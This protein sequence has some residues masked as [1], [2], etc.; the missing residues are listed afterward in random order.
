MS[1]TPPRPPHPAGRPD[2]RPSAVVS[3]SSFGFLL[4]ATLVSLAPALA[5]AADTPDFSEFRLIAERNIFNPE[6]SPRREDR[7]S[8]EERRP[9]RVESFALVGTMSYEKGRFAF[10]DGSDASYRTIVPE[11]GSLAGFVVREITTAGVQLERDGTRL[12]LT[13]NAGMRREEEGAWQPTERTEVLANRGGG[14]RSD[15]D[16][17]RRS[18]SE[19]G[20]DRSARRSSDTASSPGSGGTSNASAGGDVSDV[21]R[22]LMEQR[23]KELK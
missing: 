7:R 6:R 16:R 21:L 19:G 2:F 4:A 23:E 22:K 10:F 17:D 9:A 18:P 5:G 14:G 13:V 15:R 1:R 8:R 11:G 20:A 12:N 3:S